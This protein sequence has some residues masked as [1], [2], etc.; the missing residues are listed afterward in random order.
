MSIRRVLVYSAHMRASPWSVLPLLV[1]ACHA[2]ALRPDDGASAATASTTAASSDTASSTATAA[3]GTSSTGDDPVTTTS[4]T[5]DGPGSTSLDLTSTA[6][7]NTSGASASSTGAPPPLIEEVL[8]D[9][10]GD[11]FTP[12]EGDDLGKWNFGAEGTTYQRLRVSFDITS[13]PWQPEIPDEGTPD[14]TEHILF[15]L[16]RANQSKSYQRY[17]GGTAAVTFANKSPHFRMFGRV[18][19]AEGYMSYTQWSGTYVWQTDALY[20]V[21]CTFDGLLH[22]QRCALSLAGEVVAERF[23][24][25][26][27]LDPAAHLSSGFYIELGTHLAG[28]IEV[29]PL[30]WVY[31]DLKVVGER[32]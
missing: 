4:S 23:G 25:I 18:E 32:Y 14:R 22:E 21:E 31:R 28:D 15:G 10:P 13:G 11:V 8:L 24:A 17:L 5:G 19:I 30:G 12:S 20:H 3:S 6:D 2:G 7:A 27:Y 1:F 29:S 26:D 9:L 16:F